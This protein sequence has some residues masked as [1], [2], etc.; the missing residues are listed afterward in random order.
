M[1]H[2]RPVASRRAVGAAEAGRPRSLAAGAGAGAV[3]RADVGAR[4]AAVRGAPHRGGARGRPRAPAGRAPRH[5]RGRGRPRRLCAATG[6]G[7]GGGAEPPALAAGLSAGWRRTQGASG[8]VNDQLRH[9][10]CSDRIQLSV[11][12]LSG[13]R[14]E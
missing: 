14:C 10:G 7:G 13:L 4:S 12:G 5:G 3:R 9:N 6:A 11:Q 2:C 8:A 1:S